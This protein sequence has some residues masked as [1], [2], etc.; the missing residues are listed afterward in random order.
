MGLFSS[1]LGA[2]LPNENETTPFYKNNTPLER[3]NWFSRTCPWNKLDPE[4]IEA[5]INKFGEDP[6]FG[7]FVLTSMEQN[8]ISRYENLNNQHYGESVICTLISCIL[9]EVGGYSLKEMIRH[10]S[11]HEDFEEVKKYHRT[12]R[13]MF[14]TAIILDT[15]N[16]SAHAGMAFVFQLLNKYAEA[17]KHATRGIEIIIEIR[18]RNIPFHL[19]DI[20]EVSNSR[21]MDDLEESLKRLAEDCGQHVV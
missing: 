5:L 10:L 3:K 11:D 16:V 19:S 7:V 18:K 8:L 20:P 13:A 2:R 1:L 12:V 15:N 6:M 21:T 9:C 17:V 14:E 4:I